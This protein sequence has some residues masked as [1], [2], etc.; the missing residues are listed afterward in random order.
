MPRIRREAMVVRR[1]VAR[2]RCAIRRY[3]SRGHSRDR[4]DRCRHA[5]LAQTTVPACVAERATARPA[6][7][8]SCSQRSYRRGRRGDSSL[9]GF[10]QRIAEHLKAVGRVAGGVHMW[11]NLLRCFDLPQ[12]AGEVTRLLQDTL[13]RF[14]C[15]AGDAIRITYGARLGMVPDTRGY[16]VIT[17]G[18]SP[19]YQASSSSIAIRFTIATRPSGLLARVDSPAK[20]ASRSSLAFRCRQLSRSRSTTTSTSQSGSEMRRSARS[21]CGKLRSNARLPENR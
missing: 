11:R 10:Y 14:P 21:R 9:G 12:S 4:S 5:C 17:A 15:P 13:E 2:C 20:V 18:Q 16:A 19:K 7:H 3:A 1:A 8:A 6:Q